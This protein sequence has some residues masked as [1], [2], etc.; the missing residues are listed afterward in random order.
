MT[1]VRTFRGAC[2]E[3]AR[4]TGGR[5]LEFRLA[6][7]VTPNFHQAL[8]ACGGRT[9]AVVCTR[10]SA[11][12]A[13]AEPR[14]AAESGPLTFVEAPELVAVLSELLPGVR[15]LTRSELTGPFDA[16][17]WPHLSPADITYWRPGT[18]GE[19]LFNYWD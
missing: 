12:L 8:I 17:A 3:A 6:D 18:P 5:V 2:H 19:A 15:A 11:V 4:R 1:D 9:V 7:S 13:V 10:D 16:A 14:D